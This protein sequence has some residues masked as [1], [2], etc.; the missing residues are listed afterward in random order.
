MDLAQRSLLRKK[1]I[2]VIS[3]D[4]A[5][6]FDSVSHCQLMEAMRRFDIDPHTRRLTHNWLRGRKFQVKYRTATGEIL[7]APAEISAGLPQGGVLSPL[8]WNM[9]FNDIHA[10]LTEKREQ[11]GWNIKR[12]LDL[13]FADD[14]TTLAVV[15]TAQMSSEVACFTSETMEVVLRIRHL[16]MQRSKTQNLLYDPNVAPNGIFRRDD[17]MVVP[18]T[19]KR[20]MEQW[21]L[22]AA[23]CPSVRNATVEFDPYEET[24]EDILSRTIEH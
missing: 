6:A 4:I 13:I 11:A 23:H 1:Y 5:A 22:E 9:F 19:K 14:I 24:E 18:S 16:A 20:K 10:M 12:F 8:L 17:R 7:G 15:D 21:Q 2:Y 3:C